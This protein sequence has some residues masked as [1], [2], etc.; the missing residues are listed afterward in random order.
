LKGGADVGIL[1][2]KSVTKSFG[3]LKALS[4]VTF[5]VKQGEL[6]GVI[7]PNGSGKTTLFNVITGYYRPE[8]GSIWFNGE[9]IVGLK[10]FQ[11]AKK[12]IARTFQIVR[13]LSSLSVFDNVLTASL[14]RESNMHRARE[15][16]SEILKYVGLSDKREARPSELTIADRRKLEVARALAIE[17]RLLL[18]D[19]TLAGLLPSEID[20]TLKL[21][22]SI[23]ANGITIIMVEHVMRAIM[24]ACEKVIVLDHGEMIA[25]GTPVEIAKDKKVVAAYL[26]AEYQLA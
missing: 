5:D 12:G 10:P 22:K 15:R 26:G 1:E 2:V 25:M 20:L 13:P 19:E 18:L 16:A 14:L 6:L 8:K 9:N 7:G 3:G 21:I 4:D 23:Q 17:P 24:S 11:I